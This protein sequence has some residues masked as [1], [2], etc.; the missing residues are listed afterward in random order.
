MSLEEVLRASSEGANSV[1]AMSALSEL[2]NISY[3]ASAGAGCAQMEAQGLS[4]LNRSGSWNV[5][6][7]LDRPVMLTLTDSNGS[8][9]QV[10]LVSI[11][12]D[13]ADL[14]IGGSRNSYA[15]DEVSDLW[16]GQYTLLWRPPNGYTELLRRGMRGANVRWLRDSLAYLN[17]AWDSSAT[18]P[19]LFDVRLEQELRSFQ[20]RNR[21]EVDGVAGQQTQIII[22]SQL[23]LSETPRL[24]ASRN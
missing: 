17:P 8:S 3:D 11:D 18:D 20:R 24:T 4:C 15:L 5:L 2:W 21:L 16:F 13:T 6:R 1:A 14:V 9:Y 19:E 22:N 10:A 12:A 7:Q 23:L